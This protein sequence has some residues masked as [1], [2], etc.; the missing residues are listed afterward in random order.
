M[1]S[2]RQTA[3]GIVGRTF[4]RKTHVLNPERETRRVLPKLFSFSHLETTRYFWNSGEKCAAGRVKLAKLAGQTRKMKLVES[5]RD[6]I[7]FVSRVFEKRRKKGC[8]PS[9]KNAEKNAL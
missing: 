3:R 1:S 2:I 8:R 9:H 4:S 5:C 7:N 6:G